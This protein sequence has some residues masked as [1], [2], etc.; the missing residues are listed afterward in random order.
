[1]DVGNPMNVLK[2]A[3]ASG[4]RFGFAIFLALLASAALDRGFMIAMVVFVAFAIGI[5]ALG[6]RKFTSE[7]DNLKYIDSVDDAI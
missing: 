6:F 2:A 1:M 7:L 4:T 5:G 3:V